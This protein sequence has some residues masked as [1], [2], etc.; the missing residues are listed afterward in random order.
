MGYTL[1]SVVDYENKFDGFNNKAFLNICADFF[2]LNLQYLIVKK[3]SEILAVLPYFFKRK[4]TFDVVVKP[5]IQYYQPI[6]FLFEK[7]KRRNENEKIKLQIMNA[8]AEF[9]QKEYYFFETNLSPEIYDIRA[10]SHHQYNIRPLYTYQINLNENS[11]LNY[12]SSARK[13]IKKAIKNKIEFEEKYDIEKFITL[14]NLTFQ[15]QKKKFPISDEKLLQLLKYFFE[16]KLFRQFN[17]KY[18]NEIIASRLVIPD[19]NNRIVYDFLAVSNPQLNNLGV[20]SYLIYK[21]IENLKTNFDLFDLCG[22][23]I[24]KIAEF[25]SHFDSRL[26]TFF[27]INWTKFSL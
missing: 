9:F 20:N 22:A 18:K 26:V 11:L 8:I 4:Y 15:R 17:V 13:S 3:K 1:H 10:F 27:K 25:K 19:Q 2:H 7:R 21:V 24:P 14:H 16:K 23:N 6:E 12:H 5:F